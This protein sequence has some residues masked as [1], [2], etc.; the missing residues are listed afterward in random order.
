MKLLRCGDHASTNQRDRVILSTLAR[1]EFNG[2][3]ISI[4]FQHPKHDILFVE[5]LLAISRLN[6]TFLSSLS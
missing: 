5:W 2:P 4:S 1:V 3:F 6:S